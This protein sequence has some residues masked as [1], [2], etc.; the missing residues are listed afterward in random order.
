[1]NKI[2]RIKWIDAGIY[3]PKRKTISLSQM[4]S[5]GIIVREDDDYIVLA[6]PTTRRMSD[7]SKHPTDNPTFYIIPRG[8][9]VAIE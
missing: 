5:S 6:E 8:M 1:M 3:S 4:E 7:E 9:I 2:I